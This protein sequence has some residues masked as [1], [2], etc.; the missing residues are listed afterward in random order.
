MNAE[1]LHLIAKTIKVEL[2][3]TRSTDLMQ[4]LITALDKVIKQQNEPNE[5]ELSQKLDQIHTALRGVNSDTFSPAWRQILDEI[6]GAYLLGRELKDKLEE[7]FSRHQ[8]TQAGALEELQ[9]IAED[10]KS[11]KTAIDKLVNAFGAIGIGEEKLEPGECEFG[12]M[13]PRDYINNN[14]VEFSE[15]LKEVNFIL[16]TI[17]EVA[18]GEIQEVEIRTISSSDLLIYLKIIPAAATFIA[19]AA[20]RIIQAYKNLLDIKIRR[21]ELKELGLPDESLGGVDSYANE[22]MEDA[23]KR[24]A[25]EIF[26]QYNKVEDPS[27]KNELLV[28]I[29]IVLNKIANRIDQGFNIEVRAEPLPPPE[30]D[31]EEGSI[32]PAD[33]AM[34]EQID[35]IIEAQ[36]TLEFTHAEGPPILSLPESNDVSDSG[37]DKTKN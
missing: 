5:Q 37:K 35:R 30:E 24:I 11:F 12:Y 13:I 29:I 2:D 21:I 32:E 36:S 27:R 20:E 6:G 19:I 34:R 17:S 14:L 28:A 10:L 18:S 1:R 8:I 15:E 7:V 31:E 33:A 26:E 4:E 3:G 23:I 22:F 9:P 16:K 25:E